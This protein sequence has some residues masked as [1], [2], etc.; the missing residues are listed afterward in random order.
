MNSRRLKEMLP[1]SLRRRLGA[2]RRQLRVR[3]SRTR[4]QKARLLSANSLEPAEL[5]LLAKV[6]S[7]ISQK[8]EMYAGDGD[9]YFKV[10]VSAIDCLDEAQQQ[11]GRTT[12]KEILDLPCG[13]GRVLRFLAYRFPRARITACDLMPADAALPVAS[14]TTTSLGVNVVANRDAC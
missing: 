14:T 2:V 4:W 12:V 8:D 13:Y 1:R 5:A 10:G 6:E 9:H 3:P 11:A 7:R